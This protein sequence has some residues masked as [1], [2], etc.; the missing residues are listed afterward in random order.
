MLDTQRNQQ[1]DRYLFL[2]LN[3]FSFHFTLT[4]SSVWSDE[5]KIYNIIAQVFREYYLKQGILIKINCKKIDSLTNE[6]YKQISE[7]TNQIIQEQQKNNTSFV[8]NAKNFKAK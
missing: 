3:N 7:R 5:A 1:I 4:F 2:N 8:M 6:K